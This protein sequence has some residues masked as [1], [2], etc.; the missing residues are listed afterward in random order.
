MPIKWRVKYQLSTAQ[1]RVKYQKPDEMAGEIPMLK[2]GEIPT[3]HQDFVKVL[4]K[5]QKP[6]QLVQRN[7]KKIKQ[8]FSSGGMN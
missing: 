3:K 8:A 2:A 1:W 7:L 4:V 6:K 5:Y